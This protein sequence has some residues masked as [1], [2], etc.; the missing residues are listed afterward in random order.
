MRLNAFVPNPGMKCSPSGAEI[1]T[2]HLVELCS[3]LQ[4]V[5]S[6][7]NCLNLEVS[8]LYLSIV[9]SLYVTRSGVPA[10]K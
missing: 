10:P 5:L 7:L 1:V 6:H 4:G 2:E 8:G 9:T 3:L